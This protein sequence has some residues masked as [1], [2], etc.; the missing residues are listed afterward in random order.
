MDKLKEKDDMFSQEV[1]TLKILTAE[2]KEEILFQAYKTSSE[3]KYKE[4][5]KINGYTLAKDINISYGSII[6]SS[7]DNIKKYNHD[8]LE[9]ALELHKEYKEKK[10]KKV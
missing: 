9:N 8:D 2:Q 4:L 5:Y 1:K 3:T 6:I 7:Q 10:A